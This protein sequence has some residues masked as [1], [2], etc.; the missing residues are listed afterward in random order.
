LTTKS[1]PQVNS[2]TFS[3]SFQARLA[4]EKFYREQEELQR[5]RQARDALEAQEPA[6]EAPS[7]PGQSGVQDT[8][9][10]PM[11]VDEP[12]AAPYP[13]TMRAKKADRQADLKA[14]FRA[15]IG[16]EQL[17]RAFR[18][19]GVMSFADRRSSDSDQDSPRVTP[20]SA[21]VEDSTRIDA[22]STDEDSSSTTTS[23]YDS[24]DDSVEE[25]HMLDGQTSGIR[26]PH[27][28][29]GE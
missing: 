4:A 17:K 5:R 22:A 27:D 11:E 19:S 10:T 6:S 29:D 13:V 7:S 24:S 16:R 15:S 3:R 26:Q 2:Y 8:F 12:A 25:M 9:Y 21:A 23:A 18:A 28:H 1:A 14:A 20:H